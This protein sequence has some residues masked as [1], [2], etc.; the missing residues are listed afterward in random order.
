MAW[1]PRSNTFSVPDLF[2]P[3]LD[4]GLGADQCAEGAAGA[5]AADRFGGVI[6]LVVETF[7]DGDGLGGTMRDA[8]FAGLAQVLVDDDFAFRLRRLGH[9]TPRFSGKRKLHL[10]RKRYRVCQGS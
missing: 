2:T 1:L 9:F 8:E 10:I 6:P 4:D 3:H 5:F 7:A